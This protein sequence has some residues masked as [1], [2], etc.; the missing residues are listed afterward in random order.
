MVAGWIECSQEVGVLLFA[1]D[2][3]TH[4]LVSI[5]DLPNPLL[6][7]ADAFSCLPKNLFAQPASSA[8]VAPEQIRH[9]QLAEGFHRATRLA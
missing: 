8:V 5:L 9:A 3:L 1:T 7:Q 4:R 2:L 6:E